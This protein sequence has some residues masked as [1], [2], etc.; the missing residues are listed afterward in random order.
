MAIADGKYRAKAVEW[1]L[2]ESSNG[3]PQ[4]AI[5]FEL[6]DYD[7]S[8]I[9]WYGAFTEKALPWTEKAM[10]VCGWVGYD[11]EQLDT[12]GTNEVELV[13]VN[14]EYPEGSGQFYSRVKWVNPAGGIGLKKQMDAGGMKAFAESMKAKL[15]AL[16]PGQAQQQARAAAAVRTAQQVL[17]GGVGGPDDDDIPF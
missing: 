16:N 7:N 8:F 1:G 10:R 4:I 9:T 11:L 5:K 14:E 2:G 3:T 15:M 17:N 12:L 6:L 13:V